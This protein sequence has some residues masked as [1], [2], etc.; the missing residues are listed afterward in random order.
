VLEDGGLFLTGMNW[1]RSRNARFAVYQAEGGHLVPREFAINV[2]NIRPI[3]IISWFALHDD[4]FETR[5]MAE[6]IGKIREDSRFTRDYD[7][8]LDDVLDEI[9]YGG[10]NQEGYLGALAEG[11]DPSVFDSVSIDPAGLRTVQA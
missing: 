6:L 3:E 10:H 7:Q 9:G 1:S 8:A 11:A 5:A 4:D 2:E